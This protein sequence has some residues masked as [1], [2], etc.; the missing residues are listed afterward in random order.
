MLEVEGIPLLILKLR[1][2]PSM[3]E[4]LAMG[5]RTDGM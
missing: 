2:N 4:Y 1:L 5:I 3:E